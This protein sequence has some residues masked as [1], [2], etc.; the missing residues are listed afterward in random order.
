M[1]FTKKEKDVTSVTSTHSF[2]SIKDYL[3]TRSILIESTGE[4]DE[5][6][7]NAALAAFAGKLSDLQLKGGDPFIKYV[8][9][10]IAQKNYRCNFSLNHLTDEEQKTCIDI[11]NM[12]CSIDA[13][14]N[15]SEQNGVIYG[16][17]NLESPRL[18]NF[19]NGDFAEI[20]IFTAAKRVL[21]EYA[22]SHKITFELLPNLIASSPAGKREYD[23]LVRVGN[24][25]YVIEVK[26]GKAENFLYYKK[27]GLELGL[28][29]HHQILVTSDRSETDLELIS[30]FDEFHLVSPANFEEKFLHILH[31]NK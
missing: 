18:I 15:A 25:F 28:F 19:L 21:T 1:I 9:T 16:H 29:P 2:G 8:R 7:N 30:Y 4:T 17:F 5:K 23:L 12:L 13:L 3:A 20:A 11:A 6:Y 10:A 31:N 22:H 24:E 14:V 26:S 27:R